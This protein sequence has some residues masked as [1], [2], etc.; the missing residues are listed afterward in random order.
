MSDSFLSTWLGDVED[1][2]RP[3]TAHRGL[4]KLGQRDSRFFRA[5]C[6]QFS[7]LPQVTFGRIVIASSQRNFPG[8]PE[9]LS[10]S[11]SNCHSGGDLIQGFSVSVI[12]V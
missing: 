1:R 2:S 8:V 9:Q 12:Q 5:G 11:D 6:V 3:H 7:R 10:V 4:R